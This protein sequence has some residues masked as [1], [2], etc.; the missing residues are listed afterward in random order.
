MRHIDR[1]SDFGN[2]DVKDD[3]K[4]I[5]RASVYNQQLFD[6]PSE[7]QEDA[8]YT[9]GS[10]KYAQKDKPRPDYRGIDEISGE[11]EIDYKSI[12]TLLGYEDTALEFQLESWDELAQLDRRIID[13][14]R[15]Q[16]LVISAPTGFGKTACFYGYV[17]EQLLSSL[18]TSV[19]ADVD[20]NND[21]AIFVYPTRALLHDQLT[22][23][24]ELFSNIE[25]SG[26][27]IPTFGI[28]H[29]NQPSSSQGVTNTRKSTAAKEN[30]KT[31]FTGAT[32][33]E[34]S[35]DSNIYINTDKKA[36]Y[37]LENSAGEK[38]FDSRKFYIGRREIID[39]QPNLLLTTLESLE[40]IA[41]KP[42]YDLIN[43]ANY[44]VFDE[45]HQYSGLR[46]T[47]ASNVIRNI[48]RVRN[49]EA[50]D[51]TSPALYIGSSATVEN[52]GR[53]GRDLFGLSADTGVPAAISHEYSTEDLQVI[54]PSD[55]DIDS[56]NDDK[57]HYY[58]M[59]TPKEDDSPDVSSQFIQHAMMVGHSMLEDDPDAGTGEGRS[60]MLSFIDSKSLLRNLDTKFVDADRTNKLY[61]YHFGH[62][63]PGDWATL[64]EDTEHIPQIDSPLDNPLSVYS[65]SSTSID[66][67]R[68]HDLTLG[69]KYLE[70]GVDIESLEY[71][72]NYREPGSVA[73][74][75][76]RA[77]RAARKNGDAHMFNLLSSY[78]GDTNFYY[79]ADGFVDKDI[80]TPLRTNN[81][82]VNELHN[83]FYKYYEALAETENWSDDE[84][85]GVV[86]RRFFES[87]GWN[88][89][90]SFLQS[91]QVQF[92]R[93]LDLDI[94]SSHLLDQ[95]LG[96]V[97]R[98]LDDYDKSVEKFTERFSDILDK[99]AEEIF[100]QED[101]AR[102]MLKEFREKL[103][104]NISDFI[105]LA[106]ENG[107]GN[108]V[109]DLE[110]F[111]KSLFAIDL[112]DVQEAGNSLQTEI[113][114]RFGLLGDIRKLSR[115][116]KGSTQ[117]ATEFIEYTTRIDELAEGVISGEIQ[118]KNL[119]RRVSYYLRRS[120]E[121]ISDY[122]Q[123]NYRWGS[124]Y[125]VKSL[126]RGAYYFEKALRVEQGN[127]EPDPVM[128]Q[129]WYVP[130]NYFADTGWYF[131]LV[132]PNGKSSEE[133]ID[134]LLSQYLP[135]RTEYAAG[136]SERGDPAAMYV[137]QPE[138]IRRED[139][140]LEMEFSQLGEVHN[141]VVVPNRVPLK[142]VEDVSYERGHK[143]VPYDG[144][145]YQLLSP[146][147][148]ELEQ[149][150]SR[151]YGQV[152]STPQIATRVN[153]P[154]ETFESRNKSG[155]LLDL[156]SI[157]AQAWIEAVDLNITPAKKAGGRLFPDYDAQPIEK[158]IH[159]GDKR[160]GYSLN[161]RG[162]TL[163]IDS[164]I[165]RL[166]DDEGNIH[167]DL[168]QIP[169]H[170]DLTTTDPD[171]IVTYTTA[172]LLTMLVADVT[173]VSTQLLLYGTD[174]PTDS[175]DADEYQV[176]TF[177]QIEGGQGVVDLFWDTVE[178]QPEEVLA[179][180]YRLTRN[181]QVLNEQLWASGV[182]DDSKPVWQT[183][184]GSVSVER[185]RSEDDDVREAS[186]EIIAE[187]I[188]EQLGYTFPQTVSRII[189]ELCVT[190]EQVSQFSEEYQVDAARLA[191]LKSN[192]SYARMKNVEGNDGEELPQYILSE[193]DDVF[194]EID[195]EAIES[196]FLSPD[197][198]GCQANLQLNRTIFDRPQSE[199]LSNGLLN[200]IE[201]WLVRKV[202][203]EEEIDEMGRQSKL[204]ARLDEDSAYFLRF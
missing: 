128:G 90:N 44:F 166:S 163:C 45:I 184:I 113:N 135:F 198:D 154:E 35:N 147:E 53:F 74:L 189:D 124:L 4:A 51:D 180:L 23:V 13:T 172:H 125:A 152:Y 83:L 170:K 48:K 133:S 86:L 61:E 157:N 91:P 15:D 105:N 63:E 191:E 153:E 185:L 100:L 31:I 139:D 108:L 60:A 41:M 5:L 158:T 29:G 203:A 196:I 94:P 115:S 140:E 85:E 49:R 156:R 50:T 101:A 69:T 28:W 57:Q 17:F 123:I 36:S 164:L 67:I 72:I 92:D 173:G 68:N 97:F 37:T 112:N 134:K 174:R 79:R 26:K 107:K 143:L 32:Y 39:R 70:V 40:N 117:N 193:F 25:D 47:H 151:E 64:A 171:E 179:S 199:V 110:E 12:L 104:E 145:T 3:I 103:V 168:N 21:A 27:D 30:G 20:S 119:G 197:F 182:D 87:V 127:D 122:K 160:V 22:R 24:M 167:L 71:I 176:H 16:G 131:D 130:P 192:V 18:G 150:S 75:K 76:Q 34:E 183:F 38:L 204:S 177:E 59:L 138:V 109:H 80:S 102:S 54:T 1:F 6:Y 129:I 55:S 81:Y 10:I 78:S 116:A 190:L 181:A 146:S 106:R 194:D 33:W 65:G 52:P 118:R 142:R 201:K 62:G 169:A 148:V 7:E 186:E 162:V 8:R 89:Y 66:Q 111:K 161:T 9:T 98:K 46:G 2:L 114:N 14:G 99:D 120:L 175:S 19:G 141:G 56:K 93:L 132:E 202:P 178:S 96:G 73:A 165:E 121:A 58:F 126:L 82:V 136:Q 77:G 84:S 137:F 88:E 155:E 149:Y 11:Y 195:Q 200:E 144:A 187:L 42:H 159:R 95:R 188:E 43:T